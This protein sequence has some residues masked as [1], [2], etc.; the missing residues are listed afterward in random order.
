MGDFFRLYISDITFEN[1]SLDIILII[2]YANVFFYLLDFYNLVKRKSQAETLAIMSVPAGVSLMGSTLAVLFVSIPNPGYLDSFVE[3]L[4]KPKICLQLVFI[5]GIYVILWLITYFSQKKRTRR[6][7]HKWII[8]GIPDYCFAV[9]II[10]G[11]V[12]QLSVGIKFFTI[13]NQIFLWLY[14]YCIF[15]L[16]CK[17]IL[18]TVGNLVRLYSLK[19]TIEQNRCAMACQGC[20]TVFCFF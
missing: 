18:L 13:N 2:L 15:L 17:V 9:I 11:S 19:I 8:S 14:V 20:D 1:N 5:V 3:V 16:S 12:C 10:L 6:D 4:A 7:I